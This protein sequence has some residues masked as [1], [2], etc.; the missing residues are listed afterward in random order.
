M[1]TPWLLVLS[2]DL[3]GD[4]SLT[5]PTCLAVYTMFECVR[6]K[7]ICTVVQSLRYDTV[8]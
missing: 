7:I 8:C 2:Q 4:K 3:L 6:V 1:D 5:R